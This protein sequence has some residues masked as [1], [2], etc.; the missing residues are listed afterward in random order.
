MME[1]DRDVIGSLRERWHR[2]HEGSSLSRSGSRTGDETVGK[3]HTKIV[4]YKKGQVMARFEVGI[5]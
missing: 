5:E 4:R 1:T 2:S 3:A